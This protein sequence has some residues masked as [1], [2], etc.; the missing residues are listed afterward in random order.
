MKDL[1]NKLDEWKVEASLP[2]RFQAEVW[3]RIADRAPRRAGMFD[4]LRALFLRPAWSVAL[5]VAGIALGLGSAHVAA[6]RT[7]T[8]AMRGLEAQYVRTI[9]PLAPGS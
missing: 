7:R 5:V 9:D 6:A 3:Q 8:D 2:P 4:T 1:K